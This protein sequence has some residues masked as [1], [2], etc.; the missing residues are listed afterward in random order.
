MGRL[1]NRVAIVTGAAPGMRAALG[2]EFARALAAE[3]AAVALA[4]VDDTKQLAAEIEAAGGRA[5]PLTTDVSDETQVRA[6]VGD[7]IAAFGQVDILVN[8]AALGSNI[9]PVPVTEL[10]VADWDRFMAVNLRG[11][12]ICTKAVVA[13]MKER[14]YGKIINIG[15]TTN[16]VGLPN[17]LHYT[18]AKG[19]ILAMTRSLA[20][21]LGP[22]GIRVNSL[23]YG[24]ITSRL[25]EAEFAGDPEREA[26]IVGS[27][28]LQSHLRADDLA[29]TLVFLACKDSDAMS[30]QTVVT[31]M[32][33]FY[34]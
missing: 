21:E 23:A 22:F 4:D 13:P 5:L 33:G 14:G 1:D 29:G 32:G 24:A 28:A 10:S 19:G 20:Q 12:F 30:G 15:S 6:M 25:N 18:T 11:P 2:A 27:R 17:R 3:G 8:N 9:P 7:T 34:Y 16:M 31:D 26:R